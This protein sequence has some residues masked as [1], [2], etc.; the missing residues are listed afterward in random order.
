[1]PALADDTPPG[2]GK[3]FIGALLAKALHDNTE[4]KILVVC[5][6]NHALDQFLEDLTNIGIPRSSMVRLGKP[7]PAMD[8]ISLR[9]AARNCG[10]KRDRS[11]WTEINYLKTTAENL[12]ASLTRE[13]DQYLSFGA[14]PMDILELLEFDYP[15]YHRAFLVPRSSDGMQLA[16]RKGKALSSEDLYRQWCDGKDP[17]PQSRHTESE[18][19]WKLPKDERQRLH[20]GWVDEILGDLVGQISSTGKQYNSSITEL[21]RKLSQSQT[22]ALQNTRI[23]VRSLVITR[24]G[25]N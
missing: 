4:Q 14:R 19:V 12:S 13:F 17:G 18:A 10:Y 9:Q 21:E 15:N 6:T 22:V 20:R 25:C 24:C 3:S 1:M 2:T 11:M 8:D 5:Y 16:G 23:I 7:S